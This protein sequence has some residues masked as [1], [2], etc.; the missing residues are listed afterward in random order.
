MSTMMGYSGHYVYMSLLEW[1]RE[2]LGLFR[3][4]KPLLIYFFLFLPGVGVG[5]GGGGSE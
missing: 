5:D 2:M 3:D 4:Q 1:G